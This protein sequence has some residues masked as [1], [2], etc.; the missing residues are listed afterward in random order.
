MNEP[1]AG[2]ETNRAE[3][4]T[5]SFLDF[6]SDAF[7]ADYQRRI[8]QNP[9]DGSVLLLVPGGRF[10][11]GSPDRDKGDGLFEVELPAYYLGMTAVTNAQYKRF[12]DARGHR[13]P[14][15][16]YL[17][18]K[19]F[20]DCFGNPV[21]DESDWEKPVWRGKT[22]PAQR[23]DHP[24]VCVSWHD[25]RAYCHWAGLRLPSELEWEKAARG[26]DGREYPWGNEWD[27]GKCRNGL[28]KGNDTTCGVWSYPEGCSVWGHY[29]MSGNVNEWCED[30][31]GWHRDIDDRYRQGNL[32]PARAGPGAARMLRG[33]SWE[34]PADPDF[35]RCAFRGSM[36]PDDRYPKNGFRVARTLTP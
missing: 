18:Y 33:G 7:V 9:T 10:L 30:A 31:A 25:A 5:L 19:Q 28:N 3:L 6:L 34:D 26:V 13:P 36:G 23:A 22:F 32:T 27:V 15:G 17:E 11:A 29:Q 2:Q 35:F 16:L 4:P 12:V 8:I 1:I 21:Q 24:V 20:V 14:D